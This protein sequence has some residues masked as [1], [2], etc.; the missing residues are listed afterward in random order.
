MFSIRPYGHALILG[1]LLALFSSGSFANTA[2]QAPAVQLAPGY[3]EL[4]YPAP[5]AGTYKLP[6]IK[7]AGDGVVLTEQG[8][9]RQ[10]H[11][12]LQGQYSLLGFIYSNCSDVN[13]CPLS[14]YVFYRLKALMQE[15]PWLAEHLQ[16]LSLSFDPARDTPE[17]M[18]LYGKNFQYAGEA[19]SWRF[20]TTASEAQLWPIL[21][22]YKQDIQ[23][24]ISVNG[25]ENLDYAHVLRV[26]LIDPSLQI[27]NIYSVSF[28]HPDIL[29]TDLR[30]L[31][32]EDGLLQADA[33]AE[34]EPLLIAAANPSQ[35]SGPGDYK[36]GYNSAD[37]QTQSQDLNQRQGQAAD[38]LSIAQAPPL[39]LPPL[40]QEELDHLTEEKIELGRHLFY[41]RRLSLNDTFSC[42]MC[43]IPEQGF[44]NNEMKTAVG[45]E[46]RTVRRNAPSLYNVAYVERLFHDGR[47][48][49]LEE[50]VWTPLL[51][52][53]EMA[54]PSVGHVLNKLR[55]IPDY[56]DQFEQVFN[57]PANMLNL[58]EA[59]ASYQ[60]TLL[61]ADSAF[62]RWYFGKDESALSEDAIQGY[63]LFSGKANCVACHT[64]SEEAALFRDNRLHNTGIGYRESMG[65]RPSKR[66]VTLAPG[67]EVEVEQS[68]IDSVSEKPPRDVGLYEVTQNP[69]DRWKYTTPSLRNVALSA[70]YMHNGSLSSLKEVVQF[71]NQ[72]GVP[73]PGL[74]P[75]IKPLDLTDTEVDYLVSFLESLTGSNVDTLVADAFAAPVGDLTADDPNWANQQT[76]ALQG[77]QP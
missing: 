36:E 29:M 11:E 45:F 64:V 28:L 46:G 21:D 58:G 7:Q 70:P 18:R 2:A 47:D 16:L 4:S 77:E 31:L 17:M 73:N 8:E 42:A 12:L 34:T 41:D 75:L 68:I 6:P 32:L 5:Q 71:Y 27:R 67:V 63:R 20:L 56:K 13:G 54:N 40:P 48:T 61:S 66:T 30:T 23:R 38:L 57:E 53:N 14:S 1:C 60:M 69:S 39:G 24:E 55:R 25:E 62:D 35:L 37:Y 22:A 43:H 76:E 19:G 3:G 15:K 74:S 44:T 51:A 65:I 52:H 33:A 26:F 9:K 59:L 49:R 50:Q 10:L 72:G